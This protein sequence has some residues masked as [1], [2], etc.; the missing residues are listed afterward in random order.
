MKVPLSWLAEYVPLHL[1]AAEIAHRLTMA[2]VETTPLPNPG[3]AWGER[4]VVGRV[5]EV[6]PHPNADRLTLA[7]V[8]L[9]TEALTVVC[10]A[11]NVAEGQRIAFARIGAEL[12]NGHTGEPMQLAAAT[13]RGVVSEGMVCSE[14][15]LGISDEHEGI[16]VLPADAP[17]GE[18]LADYM[19]GDTLEVE[20][21]ANRG[22]C[23]SLLGVAR[24]L[25][26]LTGER[27]TEP[28]LDYDEGD[29][30]IETRVEIEDPSLCS[31]YTA[32]VIRGVT[33]GPS[34]EWLQRR[35]I[36]AG[37]RP[38]NTVV[39][40]TNY[41]MLEMGQPL[42]AFDLSAVRQG[43]IVV[44][45]AKAGERLVTLD[46]TDHELQ[47][48]MLLI[49]D[50]ERAL[51]LA[52]VMGGANSEMTGA[53]V[54]V[55]LESA[56]FD[57]INTRRTA[58]ALRSRSEASTRFEKG[59]HPELAERALRR[60]TRLVLE[61]AGGT[62]DHGIVDAYPSPAPSGAI[63]LSHD[64]IV[65][66]MGTDFSDDQ[67]SSVLGSLGFEV[68]A[69]SEGTVTV[70]PPY[71]RQ[72]VTIEEDVIEEVARIVGYDT[73]PDAPLD[74][75]VPD[76][77]PQPERDLRE[78][79]RDLLVGAGL[80][81]TISSTLVPAGAG[82]ADG[83]WVG[84]APLGVANP[85]SV[86]RQFL[87]TSLRWSVLRT[88]ST[89]LRQSTRGVGLFEVG[90]RFEPTEG[91]LPREREVA[92]LA[93]A[94]SR[95]DGLWSQES[96]GFDFFDAKGIVEKTLAHL[97]VRATFERADDRLLHPGR[98]AR[99]LVEGRDVGVIGELHPQAVAR[100]DLTEPTVAL[101][102]LDIGALASLVPT[103]RHSFRSFAR[104]PTA[105]R[106]LAL[107]VDR[108]MP[109]GRLQGIIESEPL[110]TRVV[111]FDQFEGA[112]LPAGKKS[113]AF[114]LQLQSDRETL[115]AEQINEAVSRLTQ[116]LRD[117]A[118]AELRGS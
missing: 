61:I 21:T 3:A 86:E 67:V 29:R 87:R 113:L 103:A 57:G 58:T 93:L 59:L 1:S 72:D 52:G 51:G 114:R 24:E 97:G 76:H 39:D 108:G 45:P 83:S 96:A 101:A 73:V 98:S 94:G 46:G 62:A 26:A 28:A 30:P 42:H 2:G 60:A 102:E 37:Q 47:P 15:E 8:D 107:L 112:D 110:V 48:P 27:V 38:I 32:S 63:E 14:R 54:D 100:F 91:D 11:P 49:A 69:P 4:I 12:R 19:R 25:A 111:L 40:A 92:T 105:D 78:E 16:L 79:V 90:R 116:R 35:L 89:A 36:A 10:G 106:D 7:T 56:T 41:V 99:I 13:I 68:G 117:D 6:A 55:L 75:R 84:P 20:V 17:V 80:Q 34:P 23:L 74:G 53:T 104:F 85:L 65:R 9:G 82:Q 109:A 5:V 81:E 95:E 70:V 33:I 50:P 64:H 88:L 66:L 77:M 44:R 115:D 71:W 118:G 31:R 22:D 43:T 18:R